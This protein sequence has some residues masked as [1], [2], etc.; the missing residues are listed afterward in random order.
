M[1][2]HVKTAQKLDFISYLALKLNKTTFLQ[3]NLQ[4]LVFL[5]LKLL[6]TQ[7]KKVNNYKNFQTK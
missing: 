7:L 2:V 6:N 1:F 5:N 4:T 3:I